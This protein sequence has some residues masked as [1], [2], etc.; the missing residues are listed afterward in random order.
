MSRSAVFLYYRLN[1]VCLL[2]FL[3]YTFTTITTWERGLFRMWIS[4]TYMIR[5]DL[6]LT[7][8][9]SPSLNF[10]SLNILFL[11]HAS[12]VTVTFSVARLK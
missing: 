7:L 1:F 12:V 9:S 10:S 3:H 5:R 2:C 8:S 6:P 4:F 11:R